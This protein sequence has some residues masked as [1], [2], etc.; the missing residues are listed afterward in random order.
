MIKWE[1]AVVESDSSWHATEH[2]HSRTA[3]VRTQSSALTDRPASISKVYSSCQE[4]M[5]STAFVL[6]LYII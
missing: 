3:E 1:V 6:K 5:S 4:S 2:K